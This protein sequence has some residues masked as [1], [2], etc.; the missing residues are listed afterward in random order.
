[1]GNVK[2]KKKQPY[3]FH[4]SLNSAQYLVYSMQYAEL[5]SKP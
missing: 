4:L 2:R 3:T 1:M 5:P